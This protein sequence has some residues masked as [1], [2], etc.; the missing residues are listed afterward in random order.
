MLL[1]ERQNIA[2]HSLEISNCYNPAVRYNS[3]VISTN[4]VRSK[5]KNI[6][7]ETFLN[8]FILIK[9][10]Q[11]YLKLKEGFSKM[12]LSAKAATHE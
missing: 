5:S 11:K 1:G 6:S 7:V 3:K 10:W 9:L 4:E 8:H 12:F 2:V